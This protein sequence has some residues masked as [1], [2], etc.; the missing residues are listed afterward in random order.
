MATVPKE[1]P[2]SRHAPPVESAGTVLHVAG[3]DF[4]IPMG[5]VSLEAFRRWTLSEEFPQ[6]GRIDYLRGRVEVDMSPESL[7][8]HN[9]PKTRISSAVDRLVDAEDLGELYG[10]RA[11]VVVE[12][13]GLSCEPDMTF[14]SHEAFEAGRV[15]LKPK[16]NRADDG[17]E[18]LGPPDLVLEVLSD[19]SVRKDTRDLAELYFKAGVREYWLVD[20]R[21]E[22]VSFRIL[23][24]GDR[25]WIEGEVDAEGFRRSDIL[26]RRFQLDRRPGRRGVWRYSLL[27]KDPA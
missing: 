24:R 12:A 14:V 21:S 4:D 3:Y 1:A 19:E 8:S 7:N 11:R 6:W 26:G 10:D 13:V 2:A 23:T 25:G 5:E 15:S 17:I 22:A 20:V 16:G 27:D 18:I 9:K